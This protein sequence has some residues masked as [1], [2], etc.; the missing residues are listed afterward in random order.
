M[1]T[2]RWWVKEA[3]SYCYAKALPHEKFCK[4]HRALMRKWVARKHRASYAKANVVDWGAW[5][6][7]EK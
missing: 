5:S 6:K 2:C 1:K 4:Q 7:F 3:K